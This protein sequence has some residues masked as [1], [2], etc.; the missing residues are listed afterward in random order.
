MPEQYWDGIS[1]KTLKPGD[2]L[3]IK[4]EGEDG[5]RPFWADSQY[6]GPDF[7]CGHVF[8]HQ[9]MKEGIPLYFLDSYL[10]NFFTGSRVRT[11]SKLTYRHDE[12]H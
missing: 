12:P 7:K 10:E 8:E 6:I 2:W 5:V 9:D 11:I 3:Q 4:V 1:P